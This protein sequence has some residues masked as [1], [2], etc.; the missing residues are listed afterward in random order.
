LY[1]RI[2]PL[3]ILIIISWLTSLLEIA[4]SHSILNY[5]SLPVEVFPLGTGLSHGSVP[6]SRKISPGILYDLEAPR[7]LQK[8]E[9]ILTRFKPLDVGAQ[10]LSGFTFEKTLSL[11]TPFF[12]GA[13]PISLSKASL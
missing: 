10:M 2:K 9:R 4:N 6:F 7:H 3:Q 13:P 8:E 12:S 11:F 5:G 1:R